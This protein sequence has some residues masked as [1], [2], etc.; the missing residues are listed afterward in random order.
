FGL[1][2]QLG[3][4]RDEAAAYIA[5]YF[6]RMPRVRSF[7]DATV[8]DAR[9]QGFV[10]TVFGRR[11]PIPELHSE[12]FQTRSLGE[13][14]AVNSVIQGSAADIIKVAM[15]RCHDRLRRDFP[16][17]RL[18]LQVHDE[19]IFEASEDEA[20]AVKHAMCAEMA[21]AYPIEPPLVVDAG[22]GRDWLSAK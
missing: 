13:R 6:E 21:G 10:A 5:R 16:R 3:V 7:I 8:A 12:S 1:A 19:L 9:R 18:V 22:I 15:I 2:Q 4:D 11:R 17:T 14:L 20:E